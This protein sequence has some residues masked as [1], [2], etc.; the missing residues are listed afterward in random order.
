MESIGAFDAKTHLSKLLERVEKGESFVIT[1]HGR[2]VAELRPL[3]R[4][5]VS[6]A[7]AA[8]EG[9]IELSKSLDL[10]GLSWRELRDEGRKY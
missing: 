8:A 9:L 4:R 3:G 5:D 2:P 7:E 1:K 6:K 10:K